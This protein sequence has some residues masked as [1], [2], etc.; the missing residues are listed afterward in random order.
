[1]LCFAVLPSEPHL[2]GYLRAQSD[3]L[4]VSAQ[5]QTPVSCFRDVIR[6]PRR[7]G[8]AAQAKSQRTLA[9]GHNRPAVALERCG[10][11]SRLVNDASAAR[12]RGIVRCT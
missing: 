9:A 11:S 7:I 5:R 6:I 2:P 3:G 8:Q 12:S 1:M 10:D 4:D